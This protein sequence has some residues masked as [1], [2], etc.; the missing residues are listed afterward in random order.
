MTVM[1]PRIFKTCLIAAL[2]LILTPMVSGQAVTVTDYAT[3]DFLD[4]LS[5]VVENTGDVTVYGIMVPVSYFDADDNLL[6]TD[7]FSAAIATFL[8]PGNRAP[9]LSAPDI[10]NWEYVTFDVTFEIWEGPMPYRD[11][12]VTRPLEKQETRIGTPYRSR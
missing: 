2:L 9:F 7:D 11:F 6:Y 8:K 10:D 4:V 1:H 12:S 3:D 5:G